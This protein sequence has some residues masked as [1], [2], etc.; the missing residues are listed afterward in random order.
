MRPWLVTS[1]PSRLI[2]KAE[3][4]AETDA[5]KQ[6]VAQWRKAFW[7]WMVRGREKALAQQKPA[8]K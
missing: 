5:E 7:D 6:R 3:V 4:L 8:G 1:N 2:Q